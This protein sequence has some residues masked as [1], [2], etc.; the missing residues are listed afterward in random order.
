MYVLTYN[1][2]LNNLEWWNEDTPSLLLHYCFSKFQLISVC[3]ILNI[4]GG[5]LVADK[6]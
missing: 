5:N 6:W 3:S 2:E 1:Y 4:D